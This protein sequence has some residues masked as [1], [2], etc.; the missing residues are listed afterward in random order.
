MKTRISEFG[1]ER[2]KLEVKKLG[3]ANS[4]LF[5]KCVNSTKYEEQIKNQKTQNPR[6]EEFILK[7]GADSVCKDHVRKELPV[8]EQS[9]DFSV[10]PGPIKDGP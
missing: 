7:D 1:R 9:I 4:K 10:L 5:E 6:I 8:S 3:I 2:M